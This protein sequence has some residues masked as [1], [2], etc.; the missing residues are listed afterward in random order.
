MSTQRQKIIANE[1]KQRILRSHISCCSWNPGPLRQSL[2]I[3]LFMKNWAVG[4]LQE[5]TILT[6]NQLR[7]W[8]NQ[9]VVDHLQLEKE[10]SHTPVV[11]MSGNFASN[12]EKI[13]SINE[14]T[15]NGN[16]TMKAVFG[17]FSLKS[18]IGPIDTL[19]VG[20]A[21]LHCNV[22]RLFVKSQAPI[23]KL[24][25]FAMQEKIDLIGV[26]LNKAANTHAKH[27]SEPSSFM[28]VMKKCHD[29]CIQTN[30]NKPLGLLGQCAPDDCTGIIIPP[31]SRLFSLKLVRHGCIPLDATD[32]GVRKTDKDFHKPAFCFWRF[33]SNAR[34]RSLVM[35][36]TR[37]ARKK[38]KQLR[39]RTTWLARKKCKQSQLD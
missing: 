28:K 11:F 9:L 29:E 20:S 23:R 16:W 7:M 13:G 34:K 6:C 1:K 30:T 27:A 39:K 24:L 8:N 31:W 26:D 15:E 2:D 14:V 12:A 32:I 22:A 19:R 36:A 37:L 25:D 21:H 18:S 3:G 17:K 33:P 35:S 5:A 38:R 4:M 10:T